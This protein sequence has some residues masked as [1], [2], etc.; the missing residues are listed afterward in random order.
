MLEGYERT[1]GGTYPGYLAPPYYKHNSITSVTKM[2][3]GTQCIDVVESSRK[4]VFPTIV[5]FHITALMNYITATSF[6]SAYPMATAAEQAMASTLS[7]Q[8]GLSPTPAA[9]VKYFE[10]YISRG[11]E[12]SNMPLLPTDSSAKASTAPVHVCRISFYCAHTTRS[13]ADRGCLIV[14]LSSYSRGMDSRKVAEAD[15][16]RDPGTVWHIS[17]TSQCRGESYAV[18]RPFVSTPGK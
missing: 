12:I 14:S 1:I 15:C 4:N 2:R 16:I 11:F 10:K 18:M 17:S 9:T 3:R 7:Y 6:F 5:R 13:T 8:L